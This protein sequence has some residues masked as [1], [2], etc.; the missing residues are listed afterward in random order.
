MKLNP[1]KIIPAL[2][3]AVRVSFENLLFIDFDKAVETK[4]PHFNDSDLVTFIEIHQPFGGSIHLIIAHN[5][6]L[7]MVKSIS[8]EEEG[9]NALGLLADETMAE[10][11]NII[12]GR[13]MADMVPPDKEF[14]FSLP[15]CTK[16][17]KLEK[18]QDVNQN[19]FAIEFKYQ[20]RPIYC[21]YKN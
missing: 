20:E 17:Q 21:M 2:E 5:H 19:T 4:K 11:C 3:N 13:F 7:E 8:Q 10:M 14:Y 1:K 12:A 9:S 6:I 18:A 15:R 16:I